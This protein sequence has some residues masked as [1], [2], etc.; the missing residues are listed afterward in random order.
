MDRP[1]VKDQ[2]GL[3]AQEGS[4]ED[5]TDESNGLGHRERQAASWQPDMTCCSGGSGMRVNR[6]LRPTI[7]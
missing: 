2:R 1:H 5:A 4:E 3:R 6:V 7:S